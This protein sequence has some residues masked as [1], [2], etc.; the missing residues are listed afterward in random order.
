MLKRL[1]DESGIALALALLVMIVLTISTT[2][3]IY[4]TTSNQNS[5]QLSLSRDGAYRMAEA[6][7]NNAMAVLGDPPDP[8][9]GIGNN[10]LDKNV[11]CG[12][13]GKTYTST[14]PDC[15]IQDTYANAGGYVIWKGVLNTG[16]AV[17]QIT[18]TGYVL[19]PSVHQSTAVYSSRTLTV[20]VAVHPTLTQ[21]LNTPVWNYIYATKPAS[22]PATV[23]DEDLFNSV[24]ISSPFYVEGNLCLHQTSSITRGPLVVK[25]RLS[26]D[27]NSQNFAGTSSVP[28]SDAHIV[29]GC[30]VKNTT[31]TRCNWNGTQTVQ[32]LD[33][34]YATVLDTTP[35]ANLTP[36]VP[37]WDNWYLN[38]SPGPY[39]P[40]QTINGQAPLSPLT[41]DNI[42]DPN[43]GDTD[44]QKLVYQNNSATTQDLT[45][46]YDYRCK[47]IAGELS[48]N[49]TTKVL[50][51]KG[52]VYIDGSVYIQ[53]GAVNRYTGQGVI[54]LGGTFLMK[55]SSLCGAVNN[56]ACDMRA[57][58][59]SPAQGWDPNAALLCFVAKGTGGQVNPGDSAQF[60]SATLQGAVYANGSIEIGTTSNVDGPMVGYQVLLG[61]SVTTSFPSITIVP[62]GMPSNPTAYAQIDPPSGYS[63]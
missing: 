15:V 10:A 11:F 29:N 61:Q 33:N 40:C 32:G 9:T 52:T 48:W 37:N 58:Q 22:T 36:P 59:A 12:L 45:P 49:N 3:L 53:N 55:N 60:V 57:V 42:V 51:I 16:T 38:A 25:G 4:Y 56:G 47:T 24:V 20:S 28:L 2:S 54:Y 46:G 17:W 6:G 23:C 8:A 43:P 35:P 7:I 44:A 27:S 62:E 5:S 50:T 41:F 63:G 19:N 21:P 31:H 18:S 34:L 39:F 1:E 26:M 13:P 30:T 14:T